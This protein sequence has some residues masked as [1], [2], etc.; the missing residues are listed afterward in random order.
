MVFY[1]TYKAKRLYYLTGLARV[2][3]FVLMFVLMPLKRRGCIKQY[4]MNAA[5]VMRCLMCDVD[6]EKAFFIYT[7]AAWRSCCLISRSSDLN[8]E[9]IHSLVGPYSLVCDCHTLLILTGW[10]A[11]FPFSFIMQAEPF[12]SQAA[13]ERAAK[14]SKRSSVSDQILLS[15]LSFIL[16]QRV[17]MCAAAVH[18]CF[19]SSP[20]STPPFISSSEVTAAFFSPLLAR[21]HAPVHRFCLDRFISTGLWVMTKC[22][23]ATELSLWDSEPNGGTTWTD[24]FRCCSLADWC[25]FVIS[26]K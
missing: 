12:W 8:I 16:S 6:D 21:L 25:H 2:K 11:F 14:R 13:T 3:C 23:W 24:F 26:L 20:P 10:K 19:T 5:C 1:N 22:A 15:S 7:R 18:W 17:R 4:E 9:C